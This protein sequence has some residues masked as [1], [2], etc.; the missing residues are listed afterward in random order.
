MA[1][2]KTTTWLIVAGR[3]VPPGEVIDVPDEQAESLVARGKAEPVEA[4]AKAAAQD[5]G[6]KPSPAKKPRGK[7]A[8]TT[9]EGL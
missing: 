4:P 8:D 9:P 2:V 3:E 5:T 6:S 7:K 1:E